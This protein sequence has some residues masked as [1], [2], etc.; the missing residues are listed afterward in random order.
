MKY[1]LLYTITLVLQGL[2]HA[3][4]IPIPFLEIDDD[5]GSIHFRAGTEDHN[6]PDQPWR[7]YRPQH[8]HSNINS[9]NN[10]G[11][12][13]SSWPVGPTAGPSGSQQGPQQGQYRGDATFYTPEDDACGTHSTENDLVA[14]LNA[15]QFGDDVESDEN[16]NCG[17][18]AKIWRGSKSVTVRIVDECPECKHGDLD[19]SPAAFNQLAD[20]DEGRVKVE[21]AWV[22]GKN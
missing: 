10:H 17:R 8:S 7:V 6:I 16:P 12:S 13:V 4:T 1:S 11:S 18:K 19:L 3:A 14:A 9:I 20:P 2:T 5:N 21:W 22:D 15:P